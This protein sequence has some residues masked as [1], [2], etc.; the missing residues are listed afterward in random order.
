MMVFILLTARWVTRV[1]L[2]LAALSAGVPGGSANPFSASA[3]TPASSG[4]CTA[5]LS[6]LSY[7]FL[8]PWLLKPLRENNS[9]GS[10][11]RYRKL[12]SACMLLQMLASPWRAC[13]LAGQVAV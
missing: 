10:K 12:K 7:L 9:Y 8:Y 3:C 2:S 4:A 1:C 6:Y 11:G 5:L 13:H